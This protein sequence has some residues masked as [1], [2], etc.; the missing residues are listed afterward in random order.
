MDDLPRRWGAYV[1]VRV[2]GGGG[3]GDVFLALQGAVGSG[4]PCVIKRVIA[5][6]Q[7]DP[8]HLNRFG[9]E[10]EISRDLSHEAIART[11]ATGTVDGEPFIAQEFIEGRNLAQLL[12][13]ARGVGEA[14]SPLLAAHIAHEVARAL[15]YAH[16]TF[17]GLVH[18][19][20][21][22][23]NIMVTFSGRVQ[24]IDFG[25]ARR[26]ADPSLTKPGIVV[27]RYSY[28]APEVLAGRPADGRA[29]IYSLGVVL[30]QLLT[31]RPPSYEEAQAAP[32]PSTL[33]VAVPGDLDAIVL[34]AIA[35]EPD[36]RFSSADDFRGALAA[37]I[38]VSFDGEERLAALIGGCYDVE[39]ERQLL[40]E[41]V[42]KARAFLDHSV[43]APERLED[44]QET[45]VAIS[46][47]RL[48]RAVLF[49]V[50]GV[51]CAIFVGLLALP[52]RVDR[53]AAPEAMARVPIVAAPPPVPAEATGIPAPTGPAAAARPPRASSSSLSVHHRKPR[54]PAG[55]LL[56]RAR[57]SL[58]AGDLA[59]A[60]RDARDV[61]QIGTATEKARAHVIVGQIRV[62]RGQTDAAASEFADAVELD[63]AN[64]AAAAGLARARGR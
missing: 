62:L 22:P 33:N 40:R 9:R 18:R 38:S 49:V 25:I 55:A 59:A 31:G 58:Q 3:M 51:G 30:W 48:A 34:R 8:V 43:S 57:D 14:V 52:R 56:D 60:E 28:T 37:L 44:S 61:I 4:R 15:A 1:L 63:P 47:R 26:G 42:R 11:L 16:E 64:D 13:A 20:V 54:L 24:L 17:G 39:R 19:D 12:S 7:A 2:L 10:A 21:A 5:D 6:T 27:G 35:S 36:R 45:A 29:D 23:E 41:E 53:P 46:S 32:P 50:F